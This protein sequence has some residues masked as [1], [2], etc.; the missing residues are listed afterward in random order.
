MAV[1]LYAFINKGCS[2]AYL[3]TPCKY[4]KILAK[5]DSRGRDNL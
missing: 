3:Y 2:R 5:C 4:E 1:K